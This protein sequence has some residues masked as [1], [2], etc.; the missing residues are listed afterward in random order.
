[1][2]VSITRSDNGRVSITMP[3]EKVAVSQSVQQLIEVGGGI[4]GETG[5][6][7]ATGPAG[8]TGTGGALGYYGAFSDYTDQTIAENTAQAMTFNTTDESNGV[9]IVSGSRITFANAGTYNVQ[10][11]GQFENTANVD[12]DVS[13]WL[14]KNGV[15]VV[16]STGFVSLPKNPGSAA[17]VLPS[18]N[19][20]FT[21]AA[22]DYY[23]FYWSTTNSNVS[24]QTYPVG[25]GPTRPS[26]ASLVLTVTQVMYTQQGPA[27]DP[28][29]YKGTTPPANTSLLWIDT[30]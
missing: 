2:T 5:A 1:M 14:R 9:S 16:G 24:I 21:V 28:G 15:D 12:A 29:V 6:T 4:R 20:V 3:S 13:V 23:Q 27:G 17:H 30:N 22:N 19:F 25:T 26:T 10:W 8:P 18:W 11:S 7:G